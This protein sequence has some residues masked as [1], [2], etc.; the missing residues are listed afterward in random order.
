[1]QAT[2]RIWPTDEMQDRRA[3]HLYRISSTETRSRCVQCVSGGRQRVRVSARP[4][5]Y[6]RAVIKPG[7][8]SVNSA[9]EPNPGDL[10]VHPISRSL[11]ELAERA[12]G[13]SHSMAVWG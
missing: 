5:C 11:T 6:H 4:R 8:A 3:I 10:C 7:G 2:I 9:R 13:V 1:M 12:A